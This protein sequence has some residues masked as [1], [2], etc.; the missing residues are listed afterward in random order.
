MCTPCGTAI[1]RERNRRI[2]MAYTRS[3]VN[4]YRAVMQK[5]NNLTHI[6]LQSG[7]LEGGRRPTKRS[8]CVRDR[9][10]SGASGLLRPLR[11][12]AMT[13]VWRGCFAGSQS[14]YKYRHREHVYAV[15]HGDQTREKPTDR[16]GVHA[17]MR[18]SGALAPMEIPNIAR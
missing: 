7:F 1:R 11:G 14:R 8:R 6:Y 18:H 17:M 13:S 3:R 15:C 12:L 16:D 9:R 4:Y 10:T 5:T 2:G